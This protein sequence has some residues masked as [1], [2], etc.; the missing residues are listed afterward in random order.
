MKPG[1]APTS[2]GGQRPL[3]GD[4][5][6]I[7]GVG[8]S[9]ANILDDDVMAPVVA[10][11]VDVEE[12]FDASLDEGSQAAPRCVADLALEEPVVR[13]GLAVDALADDELEQ[14]R[15]GPADGDLDDVVQGQQGGERDVDP[16]QRHVFRSHH[17]RSFVRE[18]PSARSASSSHTH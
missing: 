10:E 11:V 17:L 14:V 9:V 15:I 13:K 12:P 3:A 8:R 6:Q 7:V 5:R 2:S 1:A 4:E 18:K 16:S